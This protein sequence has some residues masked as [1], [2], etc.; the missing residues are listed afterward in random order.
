MRRLSVWVQRPELEPPI[1]VDSLRAISLACDDHGR[2]R[3]S[4]LFIYENEGW[5]VFEDLS[6]H[7]SGI[8]AESWLAFAGRDEFV[9]VGYNDA[10]E[11]SELI[12][13][14]NGAVIREFPDYRQTPGKKDKGQMPDESKFPIK[15]WVDV[16]SMVDV[17]E[18]AYSEAGWLWLHKMPA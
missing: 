14:Q 13:I 9:F 16:A 8:P 12:V 10:I 1:E 3:G 11:Y 6:G 5:T 4:A 2:W 18:I 7:Y 17:G 15:S